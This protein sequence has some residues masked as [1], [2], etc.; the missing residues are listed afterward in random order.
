MS[1]MSSSYFLVLARRRKVLCSIY[2][3][4]I[5]SLEVSSFSPQSPSG[6]TEQGKWHIPRR[7]PCMMIS[8]MC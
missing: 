7:W 6:C 1:S 8:N 3:A 2:E 4:W 5:G